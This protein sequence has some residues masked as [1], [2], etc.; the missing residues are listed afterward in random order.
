MTIAIQVQRE[1][2]RWESFEAWVDR[3][4]R[5]FRRARAGGDISHS[6]GYICVDNGGYVCEI[7]G[8]FMAARDAG[9]FPVVVWKLG[10]AA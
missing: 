9:R 3:A 1:L 2:F 7:G 10:V 8:D 6:G 4:A 5:D